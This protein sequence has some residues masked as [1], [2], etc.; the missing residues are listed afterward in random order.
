MEMQS[1]QS[2]RSPWDRA[3]G[4]PQTSQTASAVGAGPVGSKVESM[5]TELRR[6][7]RRVDWRVEDRVAPDLRGGAFPR[8]RKSRST[9]AWL[10][11]SSCAE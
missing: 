11:A 8:K 6:V 5:E 7:Q 10:C 4:C 9:T 2:Q 1:G 3:S